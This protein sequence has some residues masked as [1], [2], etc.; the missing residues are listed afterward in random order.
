MHSSLSSA[1][2]QDVEVVLCVFLVRYGAAVGF[3]RCV[4]VQ[5]G[6]VRVY[7]Y[8]DGSRHIHTLIQTFTILY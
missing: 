1:I 7:C 5:S 4:K 3:R 2:L 6:T 8:D